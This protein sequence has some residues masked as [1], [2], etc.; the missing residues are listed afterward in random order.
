MTSTS[1]DILTIIQEYP[2]PRNAKGVRYKYSDLLL[3]IIYAVLSGFQNGVEINEFV[4]INKEYFEKLIGLKKVPSHDTFSRVLNITNFDHL[5]EILTKWLS[6]NYPE[7][8]VKYGGIKVL[9]VDGKAVKAASAKSDGEKPVYLL[10]AMYEGQTISLQT[11][12]IGEKENE[13][14]TIVEFL[15]M[16]NLEDTIVTIDAAGTTSNIINYIDENKGMYLMQVKNNQKKLYQIID[17]E[18]T[19]LEQAKETDG[20]SLFD[21]LDEYKSSNKNHGRIEVTRTKLI[22]NTLFIYNKLGLDSFYGTIARVGVIDKKV[23]TR[24]KGKDVETNTRTIMISNYCNITVESLQTIKSSHWNIEM[25]H[26]ILDV[27]LNED[28]FTNRK[29]NAVINN[30]MLKRFIMRIKNSE[31]A[32]KGHTMKGF[33]YKNSRDLD[34]LSK[35]LFGKQAN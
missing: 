27:E 14:G 3:M 12:K 18:I 8:F 21:K 22:K 20:E 31:E 7:L 35:I 26:W 9:H 23:I 15:K 28:R 5:G 1:K 11:K 4:E 34:F 6:L 16:F 25:Q 19:R 30:S 17:E 2:D 33:F 32:Y 29:D 13:Q 10:N 24:E